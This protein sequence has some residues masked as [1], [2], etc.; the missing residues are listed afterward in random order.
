VSR[1]AGDRIGERL[2]RQKKAGGETLPLRQGF[3]PHTDSASAKTFVHGRF[4][5]GD[6]DQQKTRPA[7]QNESV[8]R[9]GA[10]QHHQNFWTVQAISTATNVRCKD[11]PNVPSEK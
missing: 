1:A 10:E 2:A 11:T 5:C 6:R 4:R 8:I 9:L 7:V 3:D